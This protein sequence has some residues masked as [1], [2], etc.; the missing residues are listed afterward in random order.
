[1]RSPDCGW[2]IPFSYLKV[3]R[4]KRDVRAVEKNSTS[5]RFSCAVPNLS[6]F[7]EC[8]VDIIGLGEESER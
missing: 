8:Y 4:V 3:D 7:S 5:S 1:M 2:F 6:E